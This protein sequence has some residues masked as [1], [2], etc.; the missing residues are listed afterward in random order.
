MA[1]P[2]L[3]KKLEEKGNEVRRNIFTIFEGTGGGHVGGTMSIV[4]LITVLYFHHMKLDPKNWDWPERDRLILSKAHCCEA[5]YAALACDPYNWIS[6]DDLKRYYKFGSPLQGHA[7]RWATPG[8]E[9]SGGSLGEGLSHSLGMA[10]AARIKEEVYHWALAPGITYRLPPKYRVYCI[11]GDG[12]CHEGQVWEAA[13]AAAKYRT[14]NLI[15]IVDYNKYCS[16]GAAAEIMKLEPFAEKWRAFGWWVT[17]INGHDIGQI[18]DALALTNNLYGD[19]LPKCI[20]AHTVKGKGI[21]LWESHHT[22]IG[23]GPEIFQGIMQ[24]RRKYP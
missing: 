2:E 12:E 5:I 4:D 19:G 14:D 17:E 9:F 3:I 10:L 15:A 13:M 7:D 22:H 11:M 23:F 20:I 8:I 24:G 21:D 18:V 6:K 1:N 16:D